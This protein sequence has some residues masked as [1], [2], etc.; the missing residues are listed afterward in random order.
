MRHQDSIESIVYNGSLFGEYVIGFYKLDGSNL[1]ARYDVRAKKFTTFG[2]RKTIIDETHPDFGIGITKIKNWEE[3]IVKIVQNNKG[4]RDVFNSIDELYF[5]FE[6][7]GK[8][9]FAG[10]H[11]INDEKEAVLLSV[12]MKKKGYLPPREFIKIFG[13][14]DTIKIPTVYY[15]GILTKDIITEIKNIQLQILLFLFLF[16]LG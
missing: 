7:G 5:Y 8:N 6:F 14:N 4:K 3:A 2:T 11:D 10:F 9:S 12:F 16:L 13:N 15:D 1:V